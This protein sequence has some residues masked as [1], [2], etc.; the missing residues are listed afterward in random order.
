MKIAFFGTPEFAVP[1]LSAILDSG[2]EVT[3]V[4]AQPNR[5]AGRGMKLKA[6]AVAKK[7]ASEGLRLL[8]AAKLRD[9][10][11]LE[12]VRKSEPDLAVVVAYGRI[13]P[14][15]LLEIPAK[16]FINVHASLLPHYRGAAPIQRAIEAGETVTGVSIMQVDAELDHGPV[17]ATSSIEIGPD[18]L[19]PELA[20]RL[21]TAGGTLLARVISEIAHGTVSAL[22]QDHGLATLAPKLEKRE[23]LLDWEWP[24][25]EAYDRFRAFFPWPG[26]T[27]Q[28]SEG[29]PLKV[30]GMRH[31]DGEGKPST[32]LRIAPDGVAV[33]MGT[34]ALLLRQIQRPGKQAS[35]AFDYA[36]GKRLRVGEP[37]S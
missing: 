26:I 37:F 36:L 14:D 15:Q 35:P 34:G 11:F 5:P 9:A 30:T 33:A 3:L 28:T 7:A 29:E 1:S 6:P 4:V 24:A 21:S 12:A 18:E 20:I 32:V 23:G 2:H 17:F 25:R 10:E 31:I 8:Q 22:A 13:L 19:A 27:L 16:G